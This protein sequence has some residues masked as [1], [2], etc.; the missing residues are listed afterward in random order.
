MMAYMNGV[1]YRSNLGKNKKKLIAS[2]VG[3]KKHTLKGLSDKVKKLHKKIIAK[4]KDLA[5]KLGKGLK[6]FAKIGKNAEFKAF[7]FAL[8]HNVGGMAVMLKKAYE[9]HP[10]DTKNMLVRL[11]K[12]GDWNKIKDALNKGDKHHKAKMISGLGEGEDSG[13]G[14]SQAKQYE[15]GAKA[16]VGI[17]KQIIA[18]FKKRKADKQAKGEKDDMADIGAD[19]LKKAEEVSVGMANS[20]DADSTIPKVDEKGDELPAHEDDENK[21]N[22]QGH[23][24]TH[25]D[26]EK[27]DT[28]FYK[29]PLVIGGAL[30][31]G[32]GAYF[33]LKKK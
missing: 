22:E 8:K 30:A 15:E 16:S 4:N 9:K 20:V 18:W 33:M 32:V 21:G 10:T 3:K 5:K 26:I 12:N 11:S 7:I 31:L 27:K 13:G 28:P 14:D 1:N 19:V 6:R 29:N 25:E 2:K 17:I 23:S 24:G